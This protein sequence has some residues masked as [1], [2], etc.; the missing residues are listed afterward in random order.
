MRWRHPRRGM[1][2]PAEFV[3]L[4]EETGL[5]VPIGE[6]VLRTACAQAKAWQQQGLPPLQ[7]AVN[8]SVAQFVQ[9]SFA[10]LIERVL[11]EIGLAPGCLELEIT[12]SLLMKDVNAA[13]T[14]LSALKEMGVH[15][16][17]DDFGTG[18]SSLN[19]LKRFPIDRLKIDRSFVQDICIDPDDA[20]IALAVIVIAHSMNLRVLA[21]GV[22][23]DVQLAFLKAR[24]CDEMQGFYFSRPLPAADAKRWLDE[25][26]RWDIQPIGQDSGAHTVLLADGDSELLAACGGM[27]GRAGYQVLLAHNARDGLD[28]LARHRVGVVVTDL[29]LPEIGGIEFL[30]RTRKLYPA[31]LRI[32]L[33][34]CSEIPNLLAAVNECAIFK[35][36][37]KPVALAALQAAVREAFLPSP[38]AGGGDQFMVHRA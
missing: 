25:H 33:G 20:A 29:R 30:K 28:L 36:L 2:P 34:D 17:I 21:E 38:L 6:W 22:E 11:S 14:I 15:L 3:P 13:V 37:A 16:A 24:A 1:V 7:M 32:A 35:L 5:I 9:P 19:Y 23:T 12:E 27:L 18:Y 10:T 26:R 31:T 8:L 4:A